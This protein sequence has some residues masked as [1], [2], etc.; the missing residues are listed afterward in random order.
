MTRPTGRFFPPLLVRAPLLVLT[1]LPLGCAR[2]PKPAEEEAPPA[3]VK[4]AA[5]QTV[6]LGEWTEL[7]GTTQP[8]PQHAAR[9]TAAVEGRVVSILGDGRGK[10]VAEGERVEAGQVI[11]QLDDRVARANRAKVDAGQK[12]L[13]EQKKQ[14]E[15][16]VELALI[17][18]QQL[19]ELLK[20]GSSSGSGLL[21]SR[22]ELDKARLALKEAES[23][24]KAV[25]AR[26]EAHHAELK[27]L[28]EQLD[29]Y[30]LRAP[31]TGRLGQVQVVT[32]QT[33]A[34]GAPVADVIDLE[35]I[36]LLCF[37]PPRTAARLALGQ[38]ARPAGDQATPAGKVVFLALQAQP[39]TGNLAVKVR[40][41]NKDQHLRANMVQRVEVL[42]QQEK[43][44]LALP[45]A[46]LLED[47]DPPEVVVVRDVKTETKEGKQEKLGK[48]RKLRATLGVRDPGRQLVE[49]VSLEDPE[50]KEKVSP[51][52]TLFVVEGGYGLHD[53]DAVKLEEAEPK[54]A[55]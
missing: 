25:A 5:A 17:Q 9:I 21:V 43:P 24:Q 45:W 14:A 49:I 32:G 11:V 52:G 27:A 13:D 39:D 53:D 30:A 50:K 20:K 23:R 34:V 1:F 55:K 35:A 42:T 36:D 31:I 3:P 15:Y 48:A 26:Q 33:L 28:D 19:E 8:L 6:P 22:V 18:V 51:E 38:S 37:V 54:E 41:P 10:A 40:F 29:L 2:A 47:R 4:V 12:E 44:R 46:A 16:A 7:L